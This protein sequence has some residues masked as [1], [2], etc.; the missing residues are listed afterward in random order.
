MVQ[1]VT[2]SLV[3]SVILLTILLPSPGLEATASSTPR[4]NAGADRPLEIRI[5][6]FHFNGT[7]P[8]TGG[9]SRF[10]VLATLS[11]W[12]NNEITSSRT[13]TDNCAF[14]VRASHPSIPVSFERS[15]MPETCWLSN[16]TVA[17][18]PGQA[19]QL[20]SG[21]LVFE[22]SLLFEPLEGSYKFSI[23][24][25]APE[26]DNAYYVN[27]SITQSPMLLVSPESYPLNW[28][29]PNQSPSQDLVSHQ[30][31]TEN[32]FWQG[33]TKT[34][35]M[36]TT[37]NP[38]AQEEVLYVA[39]IVLLLVAVLF[40]IYVSVRSKRINQI[41]DSSSIPEDSAT[42]FGTPSPKLFCS[43]CATER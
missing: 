27:V 2:V 29:L 43:E 34:T 36:T 32:W 41:Q 15:M 12:N 8:T 28:G 22:Q 9:L 6:D 30:W 21:W 4:A 11:I 18:P 37:I 31:E 19:Q 25:T 35:V 1:R 26:I 24:S 16:S 13:F 39:V 33:S 17:Y 7:G 5:I 38:I 23:R 3:F 20:I 14:G 42:D 10:H 40:A